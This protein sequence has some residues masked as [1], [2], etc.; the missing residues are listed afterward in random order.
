MQII[1]N[2]WCHNC[3]SCRQ[4]FKPSNVFCESYDTSSRFQQ[5]QLC[6]CYH[7][8]IVSQRHL[9]RQTLHATY[10]YQK[11]SFLMVFFIF[12]S[13]LIIC[14]GFLLSTFLSHLSFYNNGKSNLVGSIFTGI[15]AGGLQ[16]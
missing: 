2:N 11:V 1:I 8:Q 10:L 14:C 13:A 3:I 5:M 7:H 4:R 15:S 6:S 9:S 12:E 16:A